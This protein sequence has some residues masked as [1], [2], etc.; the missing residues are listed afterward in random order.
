MSKKL[1]DLKVGDEFYYVNG[2]SGVIILVATNVL[3]CM[4]NEQMKVEMTCDGNPWTPIYKWKE[5]SEFYDDD[6]GTFYFDKNDVIALL[7]DTMEDIK[8]D[9][10]RLQYGN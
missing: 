10:K 2:Q 6:G 3:D 8:A 9:L 4:S 7:Q 1:K 5:V